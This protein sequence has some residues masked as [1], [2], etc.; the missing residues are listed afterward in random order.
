[1]TRTKFLFFLIGFAFLFTSQAQWSVVYQNLNS[2]QRFETIDAASHDTL[3]FSG[4]FAATG[5]NYNRASSSEWFTVPTSWGFYKMSF[6]PGTKIGYGASAVDKGLMKTID[7]GKTWSLLSRP[8]T[9]AMSSVFA[10]NENNI[11][12]GGSGE[13]WRSTN[14]TTFTVAPVSQDFV[15]L[16]DDIFF[17]NQNTG[18]MITSD[19][20]IRKTTNGGNTWTVV[21]SIVGVSKRIFFTSENVGYIAGAAGIY[22]TIN[23]AQ[24]WTKIY[25]SLNME[26]FQNIDFFDTNNGVAV[27]IAGKI[28]Y[29][30]DA[31]NTWLHSNS[32]TTVDLYGVYM[33]N[34]TA[35]LVCGDKFTLLKSDN[36]DLTAVV[37]ALA[38]NSPED[39]G[40]S[41]Y[42]NPA[43]EKFTIN[44]LGVI[45]D[46]LNA[47]IFNSLGEKV[48]SKTLT[49]NKTVIDI[50]GL[51]SGVYNCIITEHGNIVSNQKIIVCT[52]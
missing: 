23:G 39:A 22:K 47:D 36:I 28:I 17:I 41:V 19:F 15:G 7:G 26:Y 20:D 49:E 37:T 51:S 4:P 27:S 30:H 52:H 31:G 10:V 29:T 50:E 16:V 34:S 12:F 5:I 32:G 35:A 45:L 25:S 33:L 18:Y 1:M 48:I 9:T 13:L 44:Y 42:P 38:E 40:I 3:L 8:S 46:Q 24:S 14:G 2:S 6:I 21:S 43:Q 11:F